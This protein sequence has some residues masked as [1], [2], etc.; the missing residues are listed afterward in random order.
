MLLLLKFWVVASTCPS[1]ECMAS[2]P[3]FANSDECLIK[4][5]NT[6]YVRSCSNDETC[7]GLGNKGHF[8]ELIPPTVFPGS[9]CDHLVVCNGS[10]RDGVCIG[11]QIGEVCFHSNSC[12]PG[13]TCYDH[14]C[15][16]LILEGYFGC[17]SDWD[18]AFGLF[19]A[20]N[21]TCQPLFSLPDNTAVE[22]LEVF[23]TAC[24]S[25]Y[26]KNQFCITP[27]LDFDKSPVYCS[28]TDECFEKSTRISSYVSCDCMY[29][30]T[31][32]SACNTAS[33]KWP[34]TKHFE[35]KRLWLLNP[36]NQICNTSTKFEKGCLLRA[37]THSFA[38][39]FIYYMVLAERYH[40]VYGAQDCVAEFFIPKF[41]L[42]DD[43][44]EDLDDSGMWGIEVALLGVAVI[45]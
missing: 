36:A 6:I 42:D 39:Q 26:C 27:I 1:Y 19:C 5:N 4:L 43:E 29:S 9:Y 41:Q 38:E 30:N 35:L 12:D 44:D 20:N 28:I 34:V 15:R 3:N 31:N 18:C 2:E 45:V 23:S 10:C 25:N 21:S 16:P 40:Q 11:K 14:V 24:R 7:E 13:L 8:C 22:C 33:N 17:R 37:A 32:K